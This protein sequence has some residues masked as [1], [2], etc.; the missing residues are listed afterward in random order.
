MRELKFVCAQ[1]DDTYYLWQVHTWLESLKVIGHSDKAVILVYTPDFREF[2]T[3]WKELEALYPEAEWFYHKDGDGISKL[4]GIYIPVLRPYILMKYFQQHPEMKECAVFYCDCDIVFTERF[5]IDQYLDDDVCYLSDTNSYINA[6]YFD[7]KKKD[8]LPDKLA[9]YEQIDVLA[10]TAK[11]VGITREIC[12]K[13]NDHS[14]GAQ[15]LLKNIDG[16]FWEKVISDCINIRT[17]LQGVNRYYFES[18]NKGFQSWCA[19]M[20][21]VLWNL[22]LRGYD[23]KV[24]A[25]L[26]F[27]WSSDHISRLERTGILHNAGIVSNRQGDI[28]T[29]YKGHYHAGL[30]PFDDPYLMEMYNDEK[31]KTLCNH[32][33]VSRMLDVKHK[34]N[35]KYN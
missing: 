18:E 8:V 13:Y 34:Y 23:T 16:Q 20:W 19:D 3:K 7:S 15:Y 30:D 33:Y 17:H 31:S 10:D 14:G 12:E 9:E 24:V 22:W 2:N 6:R 1:P 11:L 4:F 28:P 32:Y 26:E 27:A 29:F 35:L 25:E 5:N 21:A